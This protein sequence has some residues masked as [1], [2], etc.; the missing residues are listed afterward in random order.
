ML[1]RI[2]HLSLC[3]SAAY[4]N[5]RCV[6]VSQE[7]REWLTNNLTALKEEC[8]GQGLDLA[9][10]SDA[11]KATSSSLQE[12]LSSSN[13]Q[14]AAFKTMVESLSASVK[15]YN[16]RLNNL[17]NEVWTVQ[18]KVDTLLKMLWGT[19]NPKGA[20]FEAPPIPSSTSTA[21]RVPSGNG[22]RSHI[23]GSLVDEVRHNTSCDGTLEGEKVNVERVVGEKVPDKSYK[24]SQGMVDKK[25]EEIEA[26]VIEVE[27]DPGFNSSVGDKKITDIT[28]ELYERGVDFSDCL[29]AKSLRQRYDDV[30]SGKIASQPPSSS[31]LS[32]TDS[33]SVKPSATNTDRPYASPRL[34]YSEEPSYMPPPPNTG[35]A[36]LAH[37]PYPN[38]TRKM[39]DAMKFVW[40]IK[41]ELS[42]ERGI[43]PNTVDLWSGKTKLEDH[44]RLYDYPTAQSH[45]I[46]VRQKGD[47]PH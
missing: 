30:L 36:G 18:T 15:V 7:T 13:V 35:E 21:Q 34:Q 37:D 26:E 16:N 9:D 2:A 27:L 38:A 45:P 33:S 14:D 47:M 42:S 41:Q 40:Q 10:M 22:E 32:A 17:K 5:H 46:E 3:C 39:V 31:S 4:A 19:E 20:S 29:D 8:K 28:K 43:D 11:T 12:C 23:E 6:T 24:K 1:R 25:E 44:K